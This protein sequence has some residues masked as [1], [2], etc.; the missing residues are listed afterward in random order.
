MLELIVQG[1]LE[2]EYGL[3]LDAWEYFS[4]ALIDLMSMDFVYIEARIPILPTIR[5]ILLAVGWAL[6][7]GNTVFQ[8]TRSMLSGLG[9]D[10]EDPKLLFTRTFVFA[11]LLLASP[12]ICRVCLDMTSRVID[13]LGIPEAVHVTFLP[14]ATF[15]DLAGGWLL[16]IICGLIIMFQSFKLFFEM[17][18]R[19]VILAVLTITAPLAFGVGGSRQTSDVFTG[20]CR[21]FGSTCLLMAT[22]VMFIKMLL[23]VLSYT[24]NGLEAV[25]WMVLVLSIVKVAKKADAIIT[26]IGLN[27]AITGDSLGRSFPGMLTYVMART[28]VSR[29]THSTGA[30]SGNRSGAGKGR[31]GTSAGHTG[32][33]HA[34]RAGTAPAGHGGRNGGTQETTRFSAARQESTYAAAS[35]TTNYSA[36]TASRQS[37]GAHTASHAG[38]QSAHSDKSS[39]ASW[40][41]AR[42]TATA[43]ARAGNRPD[44]PRPG[45]TEPSQ[46]NRPEQP[47][48]H[49][50]GEADAKMPIRQPRHS[51]NESSTTVTRRERGTQ[52]GATARQ[53][54]KTSAMPKNA[55]PANRAPRLHHGMAGTAANEPGAGTDRQTAREAPG[56][57][58]APQE[59][60]GADDG[61]QSGA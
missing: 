45:G 31:P 48:D 43:A 55:S 11:F 26:R 9:F 3:I 27:P 13:L 56:V 58:T 6:L 17:A 24:P 15:G 33:S 59:Q 4:S 32:P 42:H 40:H 30:G 10:G 21:M 12:Q 53:E 28:A 2:W 52:A 49:R 44:R 51:R 47:R 60:G 54:Q 34:S 46:A 14:E 23:S 39:A 29:L 19:Y 38:E 61:E 8:A 57:K 25:P 22:N 18:E 36:S 5:S 41:T 50:R 20:W 37:Y 16:V 35:G 1:F 7:L